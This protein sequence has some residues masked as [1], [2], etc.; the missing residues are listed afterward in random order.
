MMFL[1]LPGLEHERAWDMLPSWPR[2]HVLAICCYV[3]FC[4]IGVLWKG[5]GEA[6]ASSYLLFVVFDSPVTIK[7]QDIAEFADFVGVSCF[8]LWVRIECTISS[9]RILCTFYHRGRSINVCVC[10]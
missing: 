7:V 9:I 5:S 6:A 2:A 8:C 4:L 1:G 10:S 3:C